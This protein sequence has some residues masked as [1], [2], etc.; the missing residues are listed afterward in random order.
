MAAALMALHVA[1][2]AKG[3]SATWERALEW[4]GTRVRMAVDAEGTG[5]RECLVAGLADVAILALGERCRR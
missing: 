3:L 5:T 4:L 2:D 1:P